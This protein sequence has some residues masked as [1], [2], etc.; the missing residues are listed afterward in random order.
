[1]SLAKRVLVTGG[2]GFIGSHLVDA[3]L[4]RGYAVRVLDNL[5]TGH[6]GNLEHVREHVEFTLGDIRDADACAAAT[7]GVE[8]VFHL[9]ALPSVARSMEAPAETNEVNVTGTMNL[10]EACRGNGVRRFVF[11]SSSS[12]Y[13]D[14]PTLPKREDQELQP[15][16]PY[17]VSKLAGE[18]YVLAYARSG[19]LEGVALRYFNIFGPRQDP[20]GPYAAVI[21]LL[22]RAVLSGTTFAIHG[23]GQQTRDFTYVKN[24]VLANIC[25]AEQ[26]AK[27]CSGAAVNV[28]AGS[29]TSL[30][31]LVQQVSILAGRNVDV[32]H[33]PARVGDVRDSLADLQRAIVAIGYAPVV[34]LEDGIRET[35]NWVRRHDVAVASR[36]RSE[37]LGQLGS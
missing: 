21:P 14:A 8:A 31:Q 26:P 22:M 11:S 36:S 10:L 28:G 29:R 35:W 27:R 19:M 9:A 30:L 1:M 13:G 16:S 20:A 33:G 17:A 3:L 2:A 25:A 4:Q 5:S 32:R 23:D 15:R 12:V 34:S 24:A 7:R 6:R 18:Q 37:T